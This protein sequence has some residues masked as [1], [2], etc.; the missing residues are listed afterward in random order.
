MSGEEAVQAGS[1]TQFRDSAETG[2]QEVQRATGQVTAEV[3]KER[4]LK[5]DLQ[6]ELV[7]AATSE[8]LRAKAASCTSHYLEQ[9]ETLHA[10]IFEV[11]CQ[12]LC[13]TQPLKESLSTWLMS[14]T[15]APN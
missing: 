12:K 13:S 5:S 8:K 4:K 9:P 15:E 7:Y 14:R 11:D 2:P 1:L 10:H 6:Q 3:L